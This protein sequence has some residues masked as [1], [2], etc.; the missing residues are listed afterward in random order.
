MSMSKENEMIQEQQEKKLAQSEAVIG[1]LTDRGILPDAG[2]DNEKIRE[3][4]KE[5]Q[6]NTYHNTM[7]LLQHY[8]TVVWLLECFPENVASELEKPFE[9]LDTLLEQ[10]DLEMSWGNRK[11]ESRMEG[12]RKSRLLLDRVNEALT[13]LKKKPEDGERLYQLIYLTYIAPE[14]LTHKE[15]LYRLDLSSRHYYR[16]RQQAVAI[17]SIRLWAAPDSAVDVW[18]GMGALIEGMGGKSHVTKL[19]QNWHTAA[20]DMQ[21]QKVYSGIVQKW[22]KPMGQRTNQ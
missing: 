10:V 17:L 20:D 21:M 2:I 5:K 4:R 7:M 8:R 15:L 9:G 18:L 3:A 13:V 16:L 11:L 19:A 12:I 22:E 14:K 1:L 6:K